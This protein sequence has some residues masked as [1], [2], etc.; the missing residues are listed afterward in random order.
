MMPQKGHNLP[1]E[2]GGMDEE[3]W[4]G[5]WQIGIESN[6]LKL[7]NDGAEEHMQCDE[8]PRRQW[9]ASKMQVAAN[10]GEAAWGAVGESAR[11]PHAG[12]V[13]MQAA[14]DIHEH[15]Q[16][17]QNET[18]RREGWGALGTKR[19]GERGASENRQRGEP[20]M[21]CKG[22]S[23][24]WEKRQR[25]GGRER[26]LRRASGGEKAG[27]TASGTE[28]GWE[29]AGGDDLAA[30]ES[31]SG[32]GGLSSSTKGLR[33]S[34]RRRAT[35]KRVPTMRDIMGSTIASTEQSG[36]HEWLTMNATVGTGDWETAKRVLVL[37]GE[38]DSWC[39]VGVVA[40]ILRLG[41]ETEQQ[42]WLKEVEE[43][44]RTPQ[45]LQK[46]VQLGW[47]RVEGGWGSAEGLQ[48]HLEWGAHQGSELYQCIE[49][50]ELEARAL[51]KMLTTILTTRAGCAE[52]RAVAVLCPRECLCMN[53]VPEVTKARRR[54]LVLTTEA[55][56][57]QKEILAKE[58]FEIGD[59]VTFFGES[60]AM[61]AGEGGAEMAALIAQRKK[62]PTQTQYQYTVAKHYDG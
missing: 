26:G 47:G 14:T 59:I 16:D 28:K 46:V 1:L 10:H 25:S 53:R 39:L 21:M 8:S 40:A 13:W 56:L 31:K 50:I 33:R 52:R 32:E 62:D 58:A 3:E 12:S 42:T 44:E 43:T 51:V 48:E 5:E 17:I 6:G 54:Y 57:T 2:G 55:D 18:D 30:A 27:E 45:R 4:G 41:A 9:T 24:S 22:E 11:E 29:R 49:E 20:G 61:A 7:A 37:K 38:M 34:T 60:V 15:T 36:R 23:D 35:D 19:M